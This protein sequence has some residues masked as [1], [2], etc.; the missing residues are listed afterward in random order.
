MLATLLLLAAAVGGPA[1]AEDDPKLPAV[2][3]DLP[4]VDGL[5]RTKPRTFPDP[6]LGYSV[7]YQA[8]GVAVSVYVYDKGVAGIPAGA[9]GEVIRKEAR[10]AADDI[11]TAQKQ[12][13]YKSVK[14]VGKEEVVRLGK[15]KDAPEAVRRRFEVVRAEGDETRSDVYVTGYKGHFV[16][17]R[18]T[19]DPTAEGAEQ[20]VAAALAAVG[21][22]LK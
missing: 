18:V 19:Y 9:G 4:E 16:K 21:G 12:G 20:K 2:K 5:T 10:Q 17:V 22:A 3:V 6:R 15:G 8:P 7:A 13:G 14:E 11:R 1:P